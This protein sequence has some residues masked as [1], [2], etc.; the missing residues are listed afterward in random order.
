M[1][2]P[3]AIA[4]RKAPEV[5]REALEAERSRPFQLLVRAGFLARGLTYGLIGGIALA[6]ALGAGSAPAAPNQQGALSL[7]AHAPLGRVAIA[8]VAAGLL[9]YALWKLSQAIFGRGPEGGGDPDLTDRIGN[10]AGGIG[11]LVFFA[12]AVRILFGSS[13]SG[14]ST[15]SKAAGGVLGWPGGPVIVGVGGAVLIAISAYQAWDAVRGKFAEDSKL[16]EMS[17]FEQRAFMVIG[18]IG[19][20]SRALVF[21][22]IGYFLVR[23][24]LSFNPHEAVGVAGA[25]GRVHRE[26]FGP[27]LLGFVGAGLL[28]FAVH[29]LFEARYR[30]L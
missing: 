24:A 5:Q 2:S 9:G 11:Y 20:I 16:H 12:V 30:R 23:T 8:V 1:P 14:S 28:V 17:P 3:D 22:L 6:L 15:P 13:S 25:L 4:E 10:A 7:I 21:M 27:W 26:P 19:L 29:S 18:R